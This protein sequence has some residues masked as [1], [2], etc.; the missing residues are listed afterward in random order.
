V[1]IVN[2]CERELGELSTSEWLT[3][4]SHALCLVE[5][6][7]L[8]RLALGFGPHGGCFARVLEG[9]RRPCESLAARSEGRPVVPL[10]FPDAVLHDWDYSAG[11]S[12]MFSATGG[13]EGERDGICNYSA[14]TTPCRKAAPFGLIIIPDI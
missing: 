8:A 11:K 12:E 5:K 6:P 4:S 1:D 7:S 10:Q 2:V 9:A 13:K 3:K 14:D